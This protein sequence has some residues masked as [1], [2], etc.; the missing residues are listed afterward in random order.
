MNFSWSPESSRIMATQRK[1]PQGA[2]SSCGS[3]GLGWDDDQRCVAIGRVGAGEPKVAGERTR[4]WGARRAAYRGGASEPRGPPPGSTLTTRDTQLSTT[5][6]ADLAL[7]AL[8]MGLEMGSGPGHMPAGHL[9]TDPPLRP[10]SLPSTEPVVTPNG[11]PTW[12][13]LRRSKPKAIST[14]HSGA[15]RK[16]AIVLK[17][18]PQGVTT[19]VGRD[20]GRREAR[21]DTVAQSANF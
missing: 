13:L 20:H 15:F 17:C 10:R 4:S 6:R 8:E 14:H 9:S 5:L 11:S 21:G 3:S 1:Y 12:T 19:L 2:L 18:R 7:D 16:G